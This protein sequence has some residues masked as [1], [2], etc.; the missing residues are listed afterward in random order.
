MY[1]AT[2]R[3]EVIVATNSDCTL[4]TNLNTGVTFPTGIW[5][6]IVGTHLL[7]VKNHQVVW[8]NVHTSSLV[9]TLAT[10]T[11]GRIYITWH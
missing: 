10:V 11:L 5:L 1:L 9:T 4:G 3:Y 7:F 6:L 8:A 2:H